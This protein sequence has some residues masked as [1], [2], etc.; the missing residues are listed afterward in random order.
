M[1]SASGFSA[2]QMAFGSH[3][4]DCFGLEDGDEDLLFAQDAFLAGQFVQRRQ[5][6]MRARE[7][8]LK[9]V[10]NSK[11]RRLLARNKTS[12]C[13][14]IDVGEMAL[15]YKAQSRKN[16]PRRRGPAR[17][18]EIDESGVAVSFQSQNF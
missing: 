10:T 4:A 11:L 6:R 18:L 14:E 5:L 12:N 13:T 1:P 9:E 7:A 15:F 2:Y 16:L 8:T 17:V 3:P